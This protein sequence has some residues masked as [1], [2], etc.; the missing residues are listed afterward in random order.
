MKRLA[1]ALI[2]GLSLS[3][4]GQFILNARI[5]AANAAKADPC[6]QYQEKAKEFLGQTE[7]INEL[8][9]QKKGMVAATSA[10][11]NSYYLVCREMERNR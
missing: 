6:R 2:L 5:E 9:V 10:A 11:N 1:V 7:K 3:I 4:L 8:F